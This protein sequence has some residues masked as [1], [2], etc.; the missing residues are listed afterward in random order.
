[1]V[2]EKKVGILVGVIVLATPSLLFAQ[3]DVSAGLE[4]CSSIDD[5]TARLACYDELSGRQ[6]PPDVVPA[7]VPAP[8]PESPPAAPAQASAESSID[9]LGSESLP[10]G[11]REEKPAVRATVTK[12]QKDSRKRYFFFFE[13]GQVWKQAS[14]KRLYFKDCNFDVTITKDYFGYK[15]QRDGEKGRTRISR[16]R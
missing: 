8:P 16:V 11:A 6:A 15:M 9:E 2:E 14:D 1:M 5:A 10:G 13:N 4:R 12:C 3:G 7:A